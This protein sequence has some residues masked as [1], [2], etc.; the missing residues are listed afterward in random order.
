MNSIDRIYRE[1]ISEEVAHWFISDRFGKKILFKFS[2]PTIKSIMCGCKIQ[3]FFM[4]DFNES[5]KYMLIGV[6]VFDDSNNYLNVTG[7]HRYQ[8]EHDAL[9]SILKEDEVYVEFLNELNICAVN[10]KLRFEYQ[11]KRKFQDLINNQKFYVGDFT[12]ETGKALDRLENI[13][14]ENNNEDIYFI[15]CLVSEFNEIKSYLY[16]E[17]EVNS[18][19]LISE[20]GTALENL[21]WASAQGVFK[22]N[23]YKNPL[24]FK[25]NKNRELTD[26]FCIL[27]IW[28]FYY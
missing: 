9:E 11:Q 12:T 13:L 2:T 17:N 10:A 5:S 24:V 27:S 19:N 18:Y 4:I 20:D 23:I 21:V 1:I 26:I 14:N 3:L 6:R 16:G 7:I 22:S 25:N 28:L 8:Y 15:D